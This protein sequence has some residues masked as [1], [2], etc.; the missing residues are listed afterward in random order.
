MALDLSAPPAI[1]CQWGR[2][3]G[4][5][6]LGGGGGGRTS[7]GPARG[8]RARELPG[9][10]RAAHSRSS[11]GFDSI[12]GVGTVCGVRSKKVHVHRPH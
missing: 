2:A 4:R 7:R 6:P 11:I 8:G 10:V 1:C 9:G 12:A 5:G 3:P